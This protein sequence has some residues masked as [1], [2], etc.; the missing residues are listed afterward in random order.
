RLDDQ[1]KDTKKVIE[2]YKVRDSE[3]LYDTVIY[4]HWGPIPYDENF[5]PEDGLKDHAFR[6]ISHEGSNEFLTF[7]MLNRA[8]NHD[9]FMKA[10]D[11]YE[12]PAQN[13]VFASAS[14]DIAMRIQGRYPARR[15]DEGKFLLDGS[16]S[17]NGWQAFIPN[18]Q[19]VM[20]KNPPRGFVSSANQYPVDDSYPY[21]ITGT[22]F[23]SY[24]NR[25][26]N[27]VLSSLSSISPEDMMALQNDNYSL[28][29]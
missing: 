22:S 13:F 6:W 28:R 29:A 24:R 7:F 2:A 19:N 23:E 1:W 5:H 12:S 14:N 17:Y 10:L 15:K 27:Q 8:K 3:V 4:T 11:Y 26:I 21:F 18:E 20:E 16:K 9:E 25:R